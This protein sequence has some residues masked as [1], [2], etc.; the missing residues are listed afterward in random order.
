[1]YVDASKDPGQYDMIIGRDLLSELGI[2]LDFKKGVMVWDL[3]EIPMKPYDNFCADMIDT[4]EQE[5]MMMHDPDTTEG[6]RIQQILDAKYSSADLRAEVEK[7]TELSVEEKEELLSCLKEYEELI[8]GSL[9]TW[10]SEPLHLE[11]KPDAKPYHAKA[12]GV[13]FSQ[14]AKLREEVNRLV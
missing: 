10:Q 8:D 7:C 14:E 13:P 11:L 3:A 12:Y 4:Y 9:G 6:E 1:M 2:V 5:V